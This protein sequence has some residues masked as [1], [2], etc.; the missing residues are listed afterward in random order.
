MPAIVLPSHD[1]S[2]R[3]FLILNADAKLMWLTAY[4][5]SIVHL[6]VK[7]FLDLYIVA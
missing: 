1:S 3:P 7:I 4:V 2:L 5:F 6:F